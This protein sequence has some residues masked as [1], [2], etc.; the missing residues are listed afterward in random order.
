[1]QAVEPHRYNPRMFRP[2]EPSVDFV[3]LE[4]RVLELWKSE[5][6]FRARVERNSGKPRWSFLDGPITANNPMGVHHAWGRTLKDLFLR[7]HAMLGRELRYQNGFDCQGLWVEVEVEKELGFK[8]KRDI[9]AYGIDRFVRRCKQRVL[10]YAARQTEQSIRLGVWMD[11]DDPTMLRSLKEA[12]GA[13]ASEVTVRTASGTEVT[14]EPESIV[15]RLGAPELGGSYFTFSDENNYCIWSFLKKCH[16]N[17]WIYKGRDAMPWCPRCGTGISE[18]EAAEGYREVTHTSLYV[19]F[20]FAD[21]PTDGVCVWT[22]TPWTL[23]ANVAAAVHPD[24]TYA[25]VDLG[26]GTTGW[27]LDGLAETIAPGAEIRSRRPGA[28]LVGRRYTTAMDDLP[29]QLDVEH[30]VIAWKEVTESEGTGIVHIAPGC[31]SDDFKLGREL[32]LSVLVPID[33]CGQYVEGYGPLTGKA[34]GAVTREVKERF[35]DAGG[36]IRAEPYTHR[37]PHCWRCRTELLFCVVD[38]WFIRMDELR[39]RIQEVTRRIGWIPEYGLQHELDWLNNMSD[40]MISKKRYWGLALPIF[41]CECG[42]FDVVGSE[43]ELEEKASAG[44]DEFRGHTPHRPWIDAV[45]VRCER[46]GQPAQRIPDVGNPWLDAGIVAYSTLR[47]RSDRDYW[48]R[49]APAD[50]IT[51]SL[52]G[53]FRNWF[54][55]LLCMSTVLEGVEPF[56]NVLGF[57]LVRDEKGEPMSKSKGNTIWFDDAADSMGV[58]PMRFLYARHNP[59]TNLNLGPTTVS[60]ARKRLITLWN[61]YSFFTTYARLD[62]FEPAAERPPLADRADLDRWI[63]SRLDRLVGLSRERLAAYDTP[64]VARA[65]ET[66][67]DELSNWYLRRSRRRFWK[68][69]ADADKRAAYATLYEVLETVVRTLAPIVPFIT[70]EI[71][72]NLVRDRVPDAPPSVHHADYPELVA[73]RRDELLE[74]DMGAALTVV[75]LGRAAR[76]QANIKVR[77]PLQ[78]LTVHAP[79]PAAAAGLDRFRGHV[80]EELNVRE[81]VAIDDASD[82]V[83][84]SLKPAWRPLGARFG[85]RTKAVV[86][87]IAQLDPAAT[88][89]RLEAGEQLVVEVDGATVPLEEG[90]V[91]VEAKGRAGLE[92]R[93]GDGFLVALDVT[94]TDDLRRE[95]LARDLVRHVQ[96]LRKEAGLAVEDRIRLRIDAAGGELMEVVAAWGDYVQRETLASELATEG[97][98]FE[99]SAEVKLGKQSTVISLVRV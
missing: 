39:P 55:A 98:A 31:G 37:Y 36:L 15:G 84:R 82:L 53:Q 47:Y 85:G 78:T 42:W 22:T 77:Q 3:A 21:D 61:V 80:L 50:F 94:I 17:G 28:E 23:A 10:E 52:P 29:A 40:W 30:R 86:A 41:E 35:R 97:D 71:W 7:F 54:Y 14:G 60:E 9:E 48:R 8:S 5:G 27:V 58:D 81:V 51:E 93:E 76:Q 16:E 2:V 13:G 63:L 38:E 33:E 44:Y 96:S 62:G 91:T 26:D 90:E 67:L 70:E 72:Q 4:G 89:R 99:H 75:E 73:G 57:A 64:P 19:R 1:V 92:V 68:G 18:T 49:W 69:E 74:R 65:T 12:I 66:F 88:Q 34:A 56:K 79:S 43:T 25:Q 46:C 11:W 45:Q 95:G 20:P 24:R 6:S 83:E 87:A 32:G 59:T